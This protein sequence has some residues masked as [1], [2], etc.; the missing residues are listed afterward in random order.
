MSRHKD[1]SF[2]FF[3]TSRPYRISVIQARSTAEMYF[4]VKCEIIDSSNLCVRPASVYYVPGD[5]GG[6]TQNILVGGRK[7]GY[8][9]SCAAVTEELVSTRS[10]SQKRRLKKSIPFPVM[11]G[12]LQ[13]T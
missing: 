3:N 7:L 10:Q 11:S 12:G 8:Q 6:S 1:V 9:V 13:D 4:R 2:F 5:D